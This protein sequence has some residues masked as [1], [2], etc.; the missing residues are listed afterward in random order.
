[1]YPLSVTLVGCQENIQRAVLSLLVNQQASLEG[2]YADV[3]SA[4]NSLRDSAT[5]LRLFIVNVRGKGDL[6]KL[7]LLTGTF[8]G[9]PVVAIVDPQSD[10]TI[11][12]GA[13]RSGAAQVVPQ[14]LMP[15]D[16]RA[17]LDCIAQQYAHVASLN[18]AIAVSGVTGGCGATTLAI[19]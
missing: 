2:Q 6:P 1:M 12:I 3:E 11:I 17:A 18:Q 4:M 14:P 5:P 19:K 7:K 9:Q 10:P 8:V 13:M 15:D 16:F